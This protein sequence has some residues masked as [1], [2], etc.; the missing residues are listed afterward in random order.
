MSNETTRLVE[1]LADQRSI[2]ECK[3]CPLLRLEEGKPTCMFT[4]EH[5]EEDCQILEIP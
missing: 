4:N 3:E 5:L 1:E 2:R